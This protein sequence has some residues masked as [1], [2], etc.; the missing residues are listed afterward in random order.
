MSP[1][2]VQEKWL[3]P[4]APV[5]LRPPKPAPIAS[6]PGSELEQLR[7]LETRIKTIE[8]AKTLVV[9]P[10]TQISAAERERELEKLR[11]IDKPNNPV[12]NSAPVVE[13]KPSEN[14][15]TMEV[16]EPVQ[17]I[18]V[19]DYK[20]TLTA[21]TT[22]LMGQIA[23]LI[24][25]KNLDAGK[26]YILKNIRELLRQEYEGQWDENEVMQALRNMVAPPY[27]LFRH[28]VDKSSHNYFILRDR[29]IGQVKAA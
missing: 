14:S 18:S 3:K 11:A 8:D 10:T 26:R 21:E 25:E 27:R 17:L 19:K 15:E 9:A 28:E 4:H 16:H 12:P 7:A 22:T 5:L 6:S 13:D 23:G 1:E 20:G 24:L 29:A 2:Q